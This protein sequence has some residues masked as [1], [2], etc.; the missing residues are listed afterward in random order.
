MTAL[1]A[2]IH[3]ELRL[4][5]RDVHGLLLLFLMPM[6]FILI[7]SLALQNQFAE[8]SGVRLTV[9]VDDQSHSAASESVLQSLANNTAFEWQPA[10]D[11]ASNKQRLGNDK[12][13]FLL[14]LHDGKDSILAAITVAP[15]TNAQV[16]ALFVAAVREAIGRER[17]VDLVNYLDPDTDPD[18]LLDDSAVTV[19]Y[20]AAKD[21]GKA[22]SSVQQSVPAWLVFAMFFVVVPLSNALIS[23]RQQG[24]LKRLRTM[25]VP[26]W[27]P[28]AGKWIPFFL[29]NQVQVV[30]MI[31]VG[32]FVVPLLG[33]DRLTLGSSFA[34]LVLM[35]CAISMAAL[36]YG[37]LVAVVARTTDQATTLGATGNIILAALGGVMVP[38][39]VMPETMQQLSMASPMAWGLEGLL[40]IFLRDGSMTSVLPEAGSLLAFGLI[41]VALAG[42]LSRKQRA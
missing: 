20:H 15:G 8:R 35:S 21:S 10:A 18:T 30:L 24:T 1:L 40:D 37:L 26:L 19:Q 2:S 38:R 3:K 11:D 41:T 27:L 29:V 32:L 14:Q 12:A 28:I 7:M 4:L 31:L 36:G 23:E 16:E 6:A 39:F 9:L 13:A 17:I 25:P 5:L 33:G 34:G 22:P 42:W